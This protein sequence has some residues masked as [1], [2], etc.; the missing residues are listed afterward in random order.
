LL[1][2]GNATEFSINLTQFDDGTLF[3]LKKAMDQNH[4]VI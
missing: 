4:D 2:L 1:A 3:S